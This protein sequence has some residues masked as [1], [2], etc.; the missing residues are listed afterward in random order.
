MIDDGVI[1]ACFEFY[2][3]IGCMVNEPINKELDAIYQKEVDS[4]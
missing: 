4:I 1:R 2:D 3:V